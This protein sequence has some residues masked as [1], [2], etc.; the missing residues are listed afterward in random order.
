M[1]DLKDLYILDIT[2]VDNYLLDIEN[3][4][5]LLLDLLQDEMIIMFYI[6]FCNFHAAAVNKLRSTYKL[7]VIED[8]NEDLR[9][10]GVNFNIK[11]DALFSKGSTF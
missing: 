10:F 6:D 1:I 3:R 9:K 4:N 2:L 7:R 11:K 5:L 8:T